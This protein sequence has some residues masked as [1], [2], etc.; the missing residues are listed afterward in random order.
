MLQKVGR[1]RQARHGSQYGSRGRGEERKSR[2]GLGKRVREMSVTLLFETAAGGPGFCQYALQQGREGNGEIMCSRR[3]PASWEWTLHAC[4]WSP[5]LQL[6]HCASRRPAEAGP[7]ALPCLQKNAWTYTLRAMLLDTHRF[8][9]SPSQTRRATAGWVLA[10]RWLPM[11]CQTD[12]NLPVRGRAAAQVDSPSN[13]TKAWVRFT[14]RWRVRQ[15]TRRGRRVG[16]QQQRPGSRKTVQGGTSA[17]AQPPLG[18]LF[19]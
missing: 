6:L 16:C 5:K 1:C 3:W 19:L 13:S 15:D 7:K 10:P 2:K 11:R 18:V 14:R 4:L 17:Q 8:F 12:A 9:L